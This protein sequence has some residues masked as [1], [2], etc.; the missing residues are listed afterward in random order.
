MTSTAP[1]AATYTEAR[2]AFLA[3]AEHAGATLASY[4][5]RAGGPMPGSWLSTWPSWA[6]PTPTPL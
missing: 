2:M 1:L 3:A 4:P 5:I 6:R